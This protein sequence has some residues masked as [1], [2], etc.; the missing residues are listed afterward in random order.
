MSPEVEEEHKAKVVSRYELEGRYTYASARC[1][2]RAAVRRA[3]AR[4][5]NVLRCG[6]LSRLWDDGCISP[7][8]TRKVLGLS[9]A[10]AVQAPLAESKFRVFRM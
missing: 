5:A 3:C 4:Q 6:A 10:A 2:A 7:R 1:A 9:L 8:D